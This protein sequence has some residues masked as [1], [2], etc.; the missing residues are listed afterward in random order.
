MHNFGHKKGADSKEK[1]HNFGHKKGADSKEKAH[2]FGQTQPLI[3]RLKA[4]FSAKIAAHT[5]V[6][7]KRLVITP[8]RV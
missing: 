5:R 2:N 6:R 7:I 1:A 8:R 4:L 3:F